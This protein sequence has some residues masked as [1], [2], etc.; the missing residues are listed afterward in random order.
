M[1]LPKVRIFTD[2]SGKAKPGPGG[3]ACC[4]IHE[5]GSEHRISSACEGLT[6]QRAELMAAILALEALQQPSNVSLFSDSQY[7]AEGFMCGLDRWRKR[8]WTTYSG[9]PV[10]NK[11]LWSRIISAAKPHFVIMGHVPGHAGEKYNTICDKM[12]RQARLD[13]EAM[14]K[15]DSERC[16]LCRDFPQLQPCLLCGEGL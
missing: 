6:S 9:T 12:S 8:N 10:A 16:T 13:L 5:D 7:L 3:Y 15:K 11:D 2:G 14:L 1:S 4:I